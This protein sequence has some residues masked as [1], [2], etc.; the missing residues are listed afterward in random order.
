MDSDGAVIV[1]FL[2]LCGLGVIV[3]FFGIVAALLIG[4]GEL[5][6]VGLLTGNG[7]KSSR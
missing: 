2:S 5:V 6:L 4:F 7:Q 1:T 3:Y